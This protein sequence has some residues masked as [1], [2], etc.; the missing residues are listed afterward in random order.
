MERM[1]YK[2]TSQHQLTKKEGKMILREI[3]NI[4]IKNRLTEGVDFKRYEWLVQ[5]ESGGAYIDTK[6]NDLTDFSTIKVHYYVTGQP[7]R[8][9][10][11]E[12]IN[13]QYYGQCL[14]LISNDNT[15][16]QFYCPKGYLFRNVDKEQTM[17]IDFD[18]QQVTLNNETVSVTVD[19]ALTNQT[20]KVF[21]RYPG[22][23]KVGVR[24][25]EVTFTTVDGD[26]L[27]LTPCK[28]LRS[29]PATLDSNSIARSAGEC[30]MYDSISGKFYGN[31]VSTGTFTVEGEVEPE[32]HTG[33]QQIYQNK[34]IEG[35]DYE[36][37]D[38]LKGDGNAYIDT[39]VTNLSISDYIKTIFDDSANIGFYGRT[40][41]REGNR[42]V[43]GNNNNRPSITV[44]GTKGF[45]LYTNNNIYVY[46]MYFDLLNNK[47]IV[48]N[49]VF[50]LPLPHDNGVSFILFARHWD[51]DSI[52]FINK[53]KFK[54]F[55]IH[56][57]INLVPCK[58]LHSIPRNLDAQCKERQTGECGMIDLISGKFYGNVANSGTFTVENDNNE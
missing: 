35:V 50:N 24:F 43:V 23:A 9:F 15:K 1:A 34:L 47:V 48:N 13:A 19:K 32:T 5:G 21:T 49:Q 27:H 55:E 58:L 8:I 31:V 18:N 12:A 28:L 22:E 42:L 40:W 37:A 36:T 20:L 11:R 46:D 39:K 30:G 7:S 29:I 45:I 2:V 57:Q 51:N 16:T 54:S 17:N 6:I 10:G 25:A 14:I 56:N 26:I 38:W 3:K 41:G 4:Y 44:W 53:A 52:D 33:L